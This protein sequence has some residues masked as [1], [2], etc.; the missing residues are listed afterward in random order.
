MPGKPQ[1]QWS[2]VPNESPA[3]ILADRIVQYFENVPGCLMVVAFVPQNSDAGDACSQELAVVPLPKGHNSITNQPAPFDGAVSGLKGPSRGAVFVFGDVAINFAGM[4][5]R[6]KGNPVALRTKEF[7]T[8]TYLIQNSGRVI[9]RDELLNEVWGYECYPCTRTVDNHI[10]QL[11]RKL[12]AEPSRP[13]HFLT[14]HGTGYK[15]LP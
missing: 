10:L 15:F 8:L 4:E 13:R 2:L 1:V 3:P 6:R 14:V 9:S 7:K 5:A 11:R 12:E